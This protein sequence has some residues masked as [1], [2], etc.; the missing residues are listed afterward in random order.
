MTTQLKAACGIA[1]LVLFV[2]GWGH[3]ALVA[4]IDHS[5]GMSVPPARP[6]SEL[7][8]EAN[9]WIGRDVPLDPRVLAAAHFDAGVEVS[10]GNPPSSLVKLSHGA[11]YNP[12]DESRRHHADD[13]D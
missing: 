7:P 6:L 5:L 1:L 11:L 4:Q 10:A 2:T 9:Q 12:P 3:R 13:E 8:L